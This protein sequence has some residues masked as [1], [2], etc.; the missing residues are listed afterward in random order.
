MKKVLLVL[1]A[2]LTISIAPVASASIGNSNKIH[3]ELKDGYSVGYAI[4]SC[5][6]LGYDMHMWNFEGV[7]PGWYVA[8]NLEKYSYYYI[9][10]DAAQEFLEIKR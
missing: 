1:L 10:Q 2:A 5:T 7:I 9:T 6:I 8:Y 3:E 4:D